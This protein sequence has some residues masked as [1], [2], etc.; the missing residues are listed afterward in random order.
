[1]KIVHNEFNLDMLGARGK[2]QTEIL[3]E[4]GVWGVAKVKTDEVSV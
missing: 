3:R 4:E 2:R 1:M